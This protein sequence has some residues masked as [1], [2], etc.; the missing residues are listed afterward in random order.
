M[1]YNLSPYEFINLCID[2][3]TQEQYLIKTAIKLNVEYELINLLEELTSENNIHDI[4]IKD[5][6]SDINGG[7]LTILK[8]EDLQDYGEYGLIFELKEGVY[9]SIE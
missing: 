4:Y 8:T 1:K 3:T 2:G 7:A 9:L 6:S 5:L